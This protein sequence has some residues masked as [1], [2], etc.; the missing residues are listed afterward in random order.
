MP[1]FFCEMNVIQINPMKHFC[2][3]KFKSLTS[4]KTMPCVCVCGNKA[5]PLFKFPNGKQLSNQLLLDSKYL[6]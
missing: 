2:N 5:I 1:V 4:C 3:L 6:S